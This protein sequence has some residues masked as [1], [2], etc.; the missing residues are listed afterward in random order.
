MK[1]GFLP[2]ILMVV[3]SACQQGT[4]Y[5]TVYDIDDYWRSSAP[6]TFRISIPDSVSGYTIN[7]DIRNTSDYEWS[8]FFA[9]YTLTDSTGAVLDSTLAEMTLFDPVSGKPGGKAGIGDLYEHEFPIRKNF[10]FPHA[11]AYII[12]LN[13]MMRR[14]SLTGIASAGIRLERT[15]Q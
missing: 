7:C 9:S 5:H 8:R 15:V 2:A 4:E 12:R 10:R 6:L 11:G 1:A 14:D 13:Q 3:F